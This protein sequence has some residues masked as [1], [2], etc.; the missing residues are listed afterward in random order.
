MFGKKLLTL[1]CVLATLV[2]GACFGPAYRTPVVRPLLGA[3]TI[4]VVVANDS[5]SR[6]LDP[7]R[8]SA[9]IVIMLN[10]RHD[11]IGNGAFHAV[12]AATA[13]SA[14][15]ILDV[16]ILKESAHRALII[17]EECLL[18]WDVSFKAS[19]TLTD[20]DGRVIWSDG[21]LSLST[22]YCRNRTTTRGANFNW[23]AP[24]V[25]ADSLEVLTWDIERKM[26]YI[27]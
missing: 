16:K 2:C 1:T 8:L 25:R 21:N 12:S 22:N 6:H 13:D 19:A 14:D 9:A 17:S 3:Q 10:R 7:A 24:N 18:V 5:E 15:A 20:R 23:D 27:N 11:G 26:L 4:L